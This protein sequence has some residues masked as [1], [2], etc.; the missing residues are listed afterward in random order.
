MPDALP[1]ITTRLP[2]KT[3]IVSGATQGLG[4]DIARCL[5]AAGA[6]VCLVGRSREAGQALADSLGEQ[7]FF[8]E[9][10]IT[11]DAALDQCL[12]QVQQRTGRVDILVNNACSYDDS[13][14][15]STRE[16]W[17]RTLDVNLISAA[18]FTQKASALMPKGSAVIN[19]CSTGGKFGADGRAIYP[20]SK[21]ALMQITRNFAVSLAPSGIRVLAVSPAWTWSPSVESMSGGSMEKAD[22]V[23]AHFH[24]LGRVGRGE[25]I[26]RVVAFAASADASWITGVDIPVDGGFSMLGPDRG[27]SPRQWFAQLMP[28]D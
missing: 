3:A 19:I 28:Q 7:A 17:H 8:C 10:D 4:A 18:I 22:A 9:T 2:G 21:A 27:I 1:E 11:S 26:G 16:Q 20:A 25:E 6:K 12:Q 13:G 15:A 23:G 24:P 5:V 14:L